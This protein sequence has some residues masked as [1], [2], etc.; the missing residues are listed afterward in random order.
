MI[1]KELSDEE[2]KMETITGDRI[3][4]REYREDDIIH[5]YNWTRDII[6]TKW[7]GRKFRTP[8]SL[9]KI[10]NGVR[11]VI[12]EPPE[13]GIFFVIADRDTEVYIGGIDLTSIDWIDKNGVLSIAIAENS[14]RNKGFATE[15]MKLLLD[16]AFNKLHLHK[17]ELGVYSDNKAAVRC[18]EKLG[19]NIEGTLKDHMLVD[20]KYRDLLQMGLIKPS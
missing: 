6:T 13:D 20:G 17:I 1:L 11:N 19:F 12:S 14:N 7:M 15:A 10:E 16:Y 3:I 4:L 8:R 2:I 18:Y 5:I 9:D